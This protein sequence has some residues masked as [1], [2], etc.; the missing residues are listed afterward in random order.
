MNCSSDHHHIFVG[1]DVSKAFFDVAA[2]HS[3]IELRFDYDPKGMANLVRHLR[4]LRPHQVVLEATGGLERRLANYL[5]EKG[6]NVAI[7]NPRQVRDHARSLN[8]LAKTDRIDARMIASFAT[9]ANLRSYEKPGE[10]EAKL[11]ALVNRRRQVIEQRV[12]ES[13]RLGRLD[14]PETATM[15]EQ[16]I[17]LYNRQLDTINRRIEEIIRK[18]SALQKRA[19][20]LQSAPG[21]GPVTTAALITELPELGRLNRQQI[22]KLIGVAPF[23]RDSGQM[24]G[25]RT[26]GGGRSRMRKNLYMATLV[27]TQYNPTI[28]AFYLR[29]QAQGKPKMV[30]LV[31]AMRKLI[32]ILNIMIRENQPWRPP[33]NA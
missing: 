10:I 26:T 17:A 30:A 11:Q 33:A 9:H 12:R 14:E 31:A 20:I 28:R 5:I 16:A 8:Q 7:V 23:N 15:I 4:P 3:K 19:A 24:R 25:R 32:I 1:I 27:A 29:L 18:N 21:I 22:A 2:T 6:F 13:N